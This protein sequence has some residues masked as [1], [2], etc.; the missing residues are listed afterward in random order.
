MP[1]R[2]SRTGARTYSL[3]L[4]VDARWTLHH[5]LEAW[6]TAGDVAERDSEG[7]VAAFER[8]D[9]G[10]CAFTRRELVA[11]ER[12]L[13]ATHYRPSRVAE[14]AAIERLLHQVSGLVERSDREN[15]L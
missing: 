14:R 7:V 3:A 12:V 10:A 5:V 13:A 8:L 6:L 15:R 1:D 9:A 4:G 2:E 11:V